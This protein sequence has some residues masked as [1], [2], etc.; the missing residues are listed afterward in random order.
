MRSSRPGWQVELAA[1][2]LD[3]IFDFAT[4]ACVL[5][6]V[7]R[8]QFT[9]Y[10]P[11]DI[12]NLMSWM[13]A[14]LGLLA[15][16]TVWERHRQLRNIEQVSL[17]TH[18]IVKKRL[19]GQVFAL[20]FFLPE[21]Q[22][23]SADELRNAD[24]I[25]VV[26]MVLSRT[27]R[28]YLALFGDR[29]K[30]GANLKFVLLDHEHPELMTIMP[31]R[32]YGTQPS[33]WWRDRIKQSVKHIEDI[34]NSPNPPGSIEVGLLPYFPSFGMWLI[35]PDKAHG[36]IIVEMYHHRTPERQPTFTLRADEDTYW[37]NMFR[38]QF[39]LLWESCQSA[40][41]VKQVL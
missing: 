18:E 8:H 1:T 9:P 34:P 10:G 12:T 23:V 16:S 2:I 38:Q 36:K 30:E 37:Y 32:S 35:D 17:E 24:D 25:Y 41:R 15:F 31:G 11:D 20:D 21:G 13:L 7:I 29:V 39:D 26:G 27:T 22:K 19:S 6:V 14:V 4:I 40:N 5:Y 28:E 33:D 3:N